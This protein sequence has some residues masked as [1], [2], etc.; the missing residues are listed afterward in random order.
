MPQPVIVHLVHHY[1]M[2]WGLGMPGNAHGPRED[3][4]VG[5]GLLYGHRGPDVLDRHRVP[6]GPNRHQGVDRHAPDMCALVAIGSPGSQGCERL[7][8]KSVDRPL[9]GGP[10]HPLIR[11]RAAPCLQPGVERVP[12]DKPSASERIAFDV[13]HATLDLALRPRPIRLTGPRRI[14][15]VAGEGL[16]DRVPLHVTLPTPEHQ[17]AGIVIQTGQWHTSEVPKGALMAVQQRA[18][19][20]MRIGPHP[21]P[22]RITQRQYE[23]M[24]PFAALA[25]PDAKLA[26]VYLGLLTRAGLITHRRHRRPGYL[27]P[28]WP[29]RAS[30]LLHTAREAQPLQLAMEHH[31][32]PAHF[33]PTLGQSLE[34]GIHAARP[35]PPLARAPLPQPPP[36]LDRLAIHAQLPREGLHAFAPRQSGQHLLYRVCSQHRLLPAMCD[37]RAGAYRIRGGLGHVALL[38]RWGGGGISD[39][40]R[41]GSFT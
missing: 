20:L 36:A 15:V 19:L 30:H 12:G 24:D 25:D 4:I 7:P 1:G 5:H 2:A 33:R 14:A 11:D 26:K 34:I 27:G 8:D 28:P 32:I 39:D 35:W 16:K 31:R 6:C 23:Q 3:R 13:L 18:Q 37:T 21:Q 38:L 17:G 41:G 40:H 10:M 29:D 9:M 22:P